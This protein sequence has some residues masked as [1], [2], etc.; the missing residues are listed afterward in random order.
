MDEVKRRGGRPPKEAHLK[1]KRISATLPT[2]MDDRV[3]QIA[4][5]DAIPYTQV[6]QRFVRR[7]LIELEMGDPVGRKAA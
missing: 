3:Q 5:R 7:G 6:I 1:V 2:W 4:E